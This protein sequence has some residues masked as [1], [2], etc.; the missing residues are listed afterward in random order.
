MT[1]DDVERL[2]IRAASANT[3]E[4]IAFGLFTARNDPDFEMGLILNKR[5]V[6]CL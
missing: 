4:S 1:P 2:V 3:D 6:E 5:D